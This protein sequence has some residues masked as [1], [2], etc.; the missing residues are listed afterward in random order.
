MLL[1][2]PLEGHA[3]PIRQYVYPFVKELFQ[4]LDKTPGM[5][6]SFFTSSEDVFAKL[7]VK[8]LL[9][10]A[11]GEERYAQVADKIKVFAQSNLR[12]YNNYT[13]PF[14]GYAKNQMTRE[15]KCKDLDDVYPDAPIKQRLLIENDRWLSAPHQLKNLVCVTGCQWAKEFEQSSHQGSHCLYYCPPSI[16]DIETQIEQCKAVVFKQKAISESNTTE[17]PSFV[18]TYQGAEGRNELPLTA[19]ELSEI[20]N[21]HT[22]ALLEKS[23]SFRYFPSSD[24]KNNWRTKN[25]DVVEATICDAISHLGTQYGKVYK[26]YMS[27]NI[28]GVNVTSDG[29]KNIAS[30]NNLVLH[31]QKDGTVFLYFPHYEESKEKPIE[32]NNTN[33]PEL[34]KLIHEKWNLDIKEE[35]YFTKEKN[36]S[37]SAQLYNRIWSL[38]KDRVWKERMIP[39]ANHVLL[40]AGAIFSAWEESRKTQKPI[41]K[42]LFDWQ[43]KKVTERK[44]KG[45]LDEQ[46]EEIK[47]YEVPGVRTR[48][49]FDC[50]ILED[51][52]ELY[53]KGL[54][55]L[56]KVNP[57][58]QPITLKSFESAVEK[59]PHLPEDVEQAS[60]DDCVIS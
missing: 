5:H 7:F 37:F 20:E 11:L 52:T 49:S 19:Q 13:S 45:Q 29:C 60:K 24:Q 43:W 51:R 47:L 48:R 44:E 1:Q 26:E 36:N 4:L 9:T 28:R 53:S 22:N 17:K 58:L 57:L 39:R 31:L 16:G 27:V 6:I 34:V 2:V 21:L 15:N 42:I 46:S 25:I 50:N 23:I 12:K 40:I 54:E 55:M 10:A 14:L 35:Y 41:S 33:S 56:Q 18:I 32:L 30:Y 3:K 59:Y 8:Q 38:V